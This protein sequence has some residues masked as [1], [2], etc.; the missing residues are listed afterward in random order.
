MPCSLSRKGTLKREE[1]KRVVK[2]KS[3]SKKEGSCVQVAPA[4]ID[5]LCMWAK[6]GKRDGQQSKGTG[7]GER[8]WLIASFCI[9]SERQD[10]AGRDRKTPGGKATGKHR[11]RIPRGER[12]GWTVMDG[13][14][15]LD[16]DRETTGGWA[17]MDLVWGP[18]SRPARAVSL[19]K[20]LCH[21]ALLA[22][23]NTDFLLVSAQVHVNYSPAMAFDSGA[24]PPQSRCAMDGR[25]PLFSCLLSG[26][27][28]G[29][30][31]RQPQERTE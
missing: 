8:A 25:A 5:F 14:G 7:M 13:W 20:S 19:D 26:T 6:K 4:R 9:W 22:C 31:Q 21:F 2:R 11:R 3:K 24:L 17:T 15:W 1:E 18:I 29:L 12:H 10:K 16:L 30:G 27:K 23:G 28:Q